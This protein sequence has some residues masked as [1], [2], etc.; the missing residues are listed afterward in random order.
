M[1]DLEKQPKKSS[2]LKHVSFAVAGLLDQFYISSFTV[3]IIYFYENELFLSIVY[4]GIAFLI[5][6]F[7]NM[8][9]DPIAG[10]ISDRSIQ[11]MK[12]WGK[13]FTWFIIASIP[14]S[15]MFVFIFLS[16]TGNYIA[17]FIW[18]LVA[19]CVFDTL[20]SFMMINWQKIFPDKFRS[21]KERTKVGGIQI[22][23]S[24]VGLTLGMILPVLFITT[25]DPGTNIPS[26]ITVGMIV[27]IIC[28]VT[29]ILILPGMREDR[30]M[31]ERTFQMVKKEDQ[32]AFISKMKFAFKQKN[33]IAYLM[34]YLAQTTVMVL[35]LASVP[36]WTQYVVNV[37]QYTVLIALFAFLLASVASSPFWIKIARKY[38][39][40]IGYMC[41]TGGTATFLIITMFI[42]EFPFFIIGFICIG[43]SM[44]ATW[45]LI[46][47]CFSDVI[48]EI[49][50]KTGKR[51][52]GVY[53]GFRTFIG[54]LS[55]VIQAITFGLIHTLTKF[56]PK[57]ST[58]SI[59]AQWGIMIAMFAVPA[60]FYFL[61]F[62][63][64]W[65]VYDLKPDRVQ[66]IKSKLKELNL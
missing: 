36:Y 20:F 9:N 13:R 55:I 8:I 29:A 35:M 32:E 51:E 64:M 65:K 53:Y 60:F 62:L 38:G 7:W 39:N 66:I 52:E 43:I 47:V 2:K 5:Y 34:A 30:E 41:G 48:D 18:L 22:L 21:Q 16:P 57:S 12:H 46:Y 11:F 25:G 14:C 56:D 37:D 26:Y 59:Q 42:W 45:S 28:I 6:G 19:L 49:V 61:G 31:I 27:S 44:G 1:S 3:R 23:Y 58:Q 10:H 33:F 63:F 54:R 50:L 24:L 15:L 17:I 4:I 40:R